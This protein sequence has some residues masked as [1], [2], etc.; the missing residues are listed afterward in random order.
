L[1][2]HE[3][4][5]S[6]AARFCELNKVSVKQFFDYLSAT[7]DGAWRQ[8]WGLSDEE[9]AKISAALQ[10]PLA[11]VDSVLSP[12]ECAADA[13]AKFCGNEKQQAQ[14]RYCPNCASEGYHS[15]FHTLSWLD[16][17]P[18]DGAQLMTHSC[19][20]G[21][22]RSTN[23]IEALTQILQALWPDWP[24]GVPDSAVKLRHLAPLFMN[25][26]R[27]VLD[28]NIVARNLTEMRFAPREN[29]HWIESGSCAH[30]VNQVRSLLPPP[31][32]MIE[33]FSA[34]PAVSP[35]LVNLDAQT[36]SEVRELLKKYGFH[37]LI[38][39]Y[40]ICRNSGPA[41]SASRDSLDNNLAALRSRH[42]SCRCRWGHSRSEGWRSVHP[43]EWP[44]W[45][46]KCPYEVACIFLEGHYGN[47]RCGQSGRSADKEF[48]RYIEC[49]EKF[50][51]VGLVGQCRAPDDR[52]SEMIQRCVRSWE[53]WLKWTGPLAEIFD[54]VLDAGQSSD[55]TWLHGW[56]SNVEAGAG[57]E[58]S[59][60]PYPAV[61]LI[62]HDGGMAILSWQKPQHLKS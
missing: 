43:D 9:T 48:F 55:L 35:D 61:G 39:F 53:P 4:V 11:I 13:F 37:E 58:A 41:G 18:F 29:G 51:S 33:Y 17:C 5:E 15:H 50:A 27:W 52:F 26:Q 2:K 14:I 62:E 1:A 16:R 8:G 24:G 10:E 32:E 31:E 3:S 7:I 59:P 30:R 28:T 56:L 45:D 44:H 12:Y 20:V 57:P 49:A 47:F 54:A 34:T 38:W 6:F 23:R 46:L 25:F 42:S 60:F 36:T 21:T 40:R 19:Y 22:D